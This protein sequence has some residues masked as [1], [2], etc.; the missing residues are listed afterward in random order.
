MKSKLFASIAIAVLIVSSVVAQVPAISFAAGPV[1]ENEPVTIS[2]MDWQSG[3]PDFW[4]RTDQLFMEKYPW[5]TVEHEAVPYGQYF[6]KVGAYMAAEEGPDLIQFETGMGI[7]KYKDALVPLND[8]VA[9]VFGDLTGTMAFCED[10]DCTK[11]I[12]GLPH[13]NQGHMIYYNKTVFKAAGL[14]PE[15]P[16][17]TW[18]EFETACAAIKK[19][20]KSCMAFGGKEW[21]VLWS[22]CNL[23]NQT[24]TLEEQQALFLGTGKFSD[25]PIKNSIALLEQMAKG[26]WFQ[27]GAAASSVTPDAQD[28]FVRGDAA[29]FHSIISDAFNWKLWGD[30]MGYANFGVMKFP[31]IEC[32]YP[33]PGVCPGP[34]AGNMDVH[35]GIAFGIPKWSKNVDAAVL[36]IKFVVSPETQTRFLL[37]GGA[38]PSNKNFDKYVVNYP[39]FKTITEWVAEPGNAV[40]ALLYWT[41]EEWNE[42]IRQS[43]L[44]LLGQATTDDVAK[45]LDAVH[46]AG[47][48]K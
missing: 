37:E 19:I 15:K 38:F 9:D 42:I 22:F 39:Q 43:Q 28:M 8:Y 36:Y 4:A 41:P 44:M 47:L 30:L 1:Q 29:F 48:K 32:D 45:A 3:G 11:N 10:F 12:Y 20:G 46:E 34:L 27:D 23:P 2:V 25:P 7:L 24:A 14:D 33:L 13:T 18:R 26:G 35:G 16:P 21:A 17:T 5:I 6:D 31:T 40:P